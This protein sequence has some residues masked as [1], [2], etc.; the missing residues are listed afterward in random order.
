MAEESD[1]ERR[2]TR[3]GDA[4]LRSAARCWFVALC[5]A[6]GWLGANRALSAADTPTIERVDVGLAGRYKVGFWTPVRVDVRGL[7]AD[8]RGRLEL[9]AADSEGMPVKYVADVAARPVADADG[10]MQL[11]GY[12]KFGRVRSS[13]VVR[14]GEG[15][16]S[17][18]RRLSEA[19][20][21][22]ALGVQQPLLVTLRQNMGMDEAVR[23][24]FASGDG[25]VSV[26]VERPQELPDR[27]YGY[28]GVHTLVIGTSDAAWLEQL[29][30]E[31]LAAID[32]WLRLGGRLVLSAGNRAAELAG[33]GTPWSEWIPGRV[34][35]VVDLRRS[36]GLESY[37]TAEQRLLGADGAERLRFAL[38]EGVRGRIEATET[39]AAL[40]DRPVVVTSPVGFGQVVFV[41][42]DLEDA[43]TSTWRGRPR[44]MGK[45]LQTDRSLIQSETSGRESQGQVS[46]LGFDDLSG[47]LRSALDQFPGVSTVPFGWIVTMVIAYIALIG[48]LD[49]FLHRKLGRAEATWITFPLAAVGFAALALWLGGRGKESRLRVNQVDVVDVDATT[50]LARGTTWLNV[51]S[52]HSLT[53]DWRF[54]VEARD[55]RLAVGE[56]LASWQGVPGRGVGALGST[57]TSLLAT[58]SYV[59][60]L[61]TP[62]TELGSLEAL[63]ISVAGTRC[64]S[65]R[66]RGR[67]T[68][69]ADAALRSDSLD[70]QLQGR[71]RNP[72]NF[73]LTDWALLRGN[74]MY[75]GERDLEPGEEV[76]MAE[77]SAARYLD[78]HL[79]RRRVSSDAKDYTAPWD[80][81]S[82]ETP[83]IVE[84]MMFHRSAG[85]S[86]YTRIAG[87]YQQYLDL[88]DQLRLG[89]AI[90]VGRGPTACRPSRDGA[91]IGDDYEQ[92]TAFY[93]VVVPVEFGRSGSGAR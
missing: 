69:D 81:G 44:L 9:I 2:R 50:G 22:A 93:R 45:L 43:P 33:R 17:V 51:Y 8:W 10:A 85:G 74:W 18:E 86:S 20:V 36:A 56:F 28:E 27:W 11:T 71:F 80:E 31:Q 58:G 34:A 16:S 54:D 12:V 48:P 39:L 32:E 72:W 73:P 41:G 79:T 1:G 76:T 67:A 52:P 68:L 57:A 66:W 53:S 65:G 75:R 26:L 3:G 38:L 61:P 62:P 14:L 55:G 42:I 84:M 90:L 4:A 19:E 59:T 13:L 78:W 5:V 37:A 91:S 21:P 25:A 40:G 6:V 63:P 23:F 49:F 24:A 30:P 46:H 15:E 87:R 35:E 60:R 88:T 82:F 70:G 83:R 89:R 64:L 7:P 77:F 47:Q 92:S 29:A